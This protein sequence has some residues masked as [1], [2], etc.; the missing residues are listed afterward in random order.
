MKNWLF[1]LWV[2]SVSTTAYPISVQRII[3]KDGS[4]ING[5]IQKQDGNGNLTIQSEQAIICLKGND[6][7]IF[8]EKK[9]KVQSLDKAWIEWAE[10]H[11]AFEGDK[12]NRT[13]LLCD[14]SV[15]KNREIQKV[16]ILE[17]GVVLKYQDMTPATYSVKWEDVKAIQEEKRSQT[18]L[19]GLNRTYFLKSG[20]EYEGQ[21]YEETDS[22]LSLYLSDG[23][24]QSFNIDD[25]EKYSFHK[26]QSRHLRTKSITRNHNQNQWR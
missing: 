9:Y 11:N 20:V 5:F 26:S 4:V 25:V 1:L 2:V 16:R 19:S 21:F 10:K 8:N 7:T 6:A 12:D 15:K 14:I 3:L 13:L 23:I 18:A 17:R 24:I 22:T